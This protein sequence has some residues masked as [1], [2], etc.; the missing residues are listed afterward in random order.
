MNPVPWPFGA[1]KLFGYDFIMADPPWPTTLRSPKGEA[2]SSV[3]K[4]GAM[5]FEAIAA[6]PRSASSPAATRCCGCGA[7]GRCCSTAAIP[8]ATTRAPTPHARIRARS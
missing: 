4:Y 7:P 8:S 1:L 6:L 5:S 3:A 2:K